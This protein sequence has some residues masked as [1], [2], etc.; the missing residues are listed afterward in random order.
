M[1]NVVDRL[2]LELLDW[3]SRH[4]ATYAELIEVWRTNC[5]R[6]STW[7]DAVI[8]GLVEVK[9]DKITLTPRGLQMLNGVPESS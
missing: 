7:E 5:P 3:I 2:M 1:E 6:H 9:D 4:S 8:A